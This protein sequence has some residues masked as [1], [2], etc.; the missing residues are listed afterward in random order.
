MEPQERGEST[1]LRKSCRGLTGQRTV[2]EIFSLEPCP[3]RDSGEHP[4]TDF[5]LVKAKTKS[6]E[7]SRARVLWSRSH[8]SVA[9]RFGPGPRKRDVPWQLAN[10]PRAMPRGRK[11]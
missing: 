11:C 10:W 2:L 7:P 4:R 8:A 9:S 6:A 5:F 3:S 1:N